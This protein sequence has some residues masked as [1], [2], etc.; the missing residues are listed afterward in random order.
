MWEQHFFHFQIKFIHNA[1]ERQSTE[2]VQMS[3]LTSQA[4]REEVRRNQLIDQ[5]SREEGRSNQL[6]SQ[7]T[8]EQAEW[9]QLICHDNRE[10]VEGNQLTYHVN[11]EKV[12][13]NQLTCHVNREQVERNQLTYHVNREQVEKTELTSKVK[14][15]EERNQLTG[16]L[17]TKDPLASR[18]LL[19]DIS[20]H[21][22]NPFI[23]GANSQSEEN[24]EKRS[25]QRLRQWTLCIMLPAIVVRTFY[26]SLTAQ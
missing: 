20:A 22:K 2:Y 26:L 5:V 1:A 9:R 11:R 4:N 8:S 23:K 19:R 13:R 12:K 15:K 16:Q 10:D 3:R 25:R 24:N 6:L 7:V 14:E 21:L 18:K 17:Y